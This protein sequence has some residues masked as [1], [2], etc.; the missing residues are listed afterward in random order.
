KWL[1]VTC[2]GYTGYRNAR[3]GRIEAHEA[4]CAWAREVMLE[5]I[6]AA[7]ADG[8]DVVHGIVD[9]LWITDASGRGFNERAEAAQRLA[10]R[11]CWYVN[12]VLGLWFRCG[13]SQGH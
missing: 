5:G 6:E 7:R 3:F 4:I 10:F 1:L 2:F 8:W 11:R 9:S 13:Q 12:T